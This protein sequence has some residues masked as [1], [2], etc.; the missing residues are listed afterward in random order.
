M[1]IHSVVSL[2]LQKNPMMIWIDTK[3][4]HGGGKPTAKI[5]EE[6]ADI[7]AFMHGAVGLT[8]TD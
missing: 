7:A 6:Q 2:V 8:W 3:A 1:I 5:I 4:G